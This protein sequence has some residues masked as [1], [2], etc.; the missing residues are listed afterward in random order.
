MDGVTHPL[1]QQVT[2]T[3]AAALVPVTVPAVYDWAA[4]ARRLY[5]WCESTARPGDYYDGHAAE[6]AVQ[7]F[8]RYLTHTK[9]RWA[10]QRFELLPWQV[11]VV[12]TIFGWKRVDHSRRF[13]I[14]Y[15]E[16]PRKNGKTGLAAGIALYLAFCSGEAGAEVYCAATDK[17]QAAICFGEAKKMRL[18]SPQ[19]L[20]RTL[21]YKFAVSRPD[22]FSKLEVVSADYGNKDGLNISGLVG[23]EMHAWR[24]R[25]LY[26]V[27]HTATGARSEPLEFLITTAGEDP[28]GICWELHERG[29]EV[30]ERRIDDHGFLPVIFA[31]DPPTDPDKETEWLLD[32]ATWAQ[33]NPSLGNTVGLDYLSAEAN[34]AV[35]QPRYRNTFKRYHLGAWTQQGTI[36]LPYERWKAGSRGKD[37]VTIEALKGR[38]GFFGLDLSATTDLT[39]LIGVFPPEAEGGTWDLWSHFW[40]PEA[41]LKERTRKDKVPYDLWREQGYI[42]ATPGDVIDYAYIRR[43]LTG[44]GDE[45]PPA[46]FKPLRDQMEIAELAFDR[47]GSHYLI[48]QLGEND[49]MPVIA[50][51]QGYISM[52][53]PSKE[54]EKLVLAGRVNAGDN[55]VMDWMARI[56][57]VRQDDAGNIKP[58]KPD[59]RKSTKR[60]DGIVGAVM[61]LGRAIAP[62]NANLVNLGKLIEVGFAIS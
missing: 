33:A 58:V 22:T 42:T 32:P 26:E 62:E 2:A 17:N 1:G 52:S 48:T 35:T 7:F 38:R 14:V 23:D 49:G 44:K 18:K 10:G 40:M 13:R 24:D 15:I 9:G 54:M 50:F 19:L 36:W 51:G 3:S 16:I 31:A 59:R 6:H 47:Y 30:W 39:A 11:A 34:R 55:P 57:E 21:A 43:M 37:S 29:I 61:G 60:I 56:V 4:W 12:R 5:E 27:L 28:E 46:G 41:N 53:G 20:E 25:E 45:A 8:P